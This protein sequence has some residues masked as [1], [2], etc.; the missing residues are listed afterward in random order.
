[1]IHETRLSVVAEVPLS[2]FTFETE[3]DTYRAWFSLLVMI[4]DQ[5]GKIVRKVSQDYP[6]EGPSDKVKSLLASEI[7]F[8][9]H[10]QLP[11]GRYSVEVAAYDRESNRAGARRSILVVPSKPEGVE[12]SSLSVIRRIDPVDA[13][14]DD[15]ENPFLVESGKIVPDLKG[16]I[17]SESGGEVG[18]FMLVYP[19][20]GGTEDPVLLLDVSRDGQ[21]VGQ[22]LLDLPAPNEDGEI[23]YVA[24]LP[25]SGL[26]P[27]RYEVRAEAR[28][29]S[30][31]AVEHLFFTVD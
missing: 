24:T 4:R 22:V 31:S 8:I 21:A 16:R 27:G 30:T 7:I 29:G 15:E 18:I 2:N 14:A 20:K 6:L 3:G 9:R 12:I 5:D 19:N 28:Q 13:G 23:P 11:P 10:V 17:Q 25:V 26:E 1:M